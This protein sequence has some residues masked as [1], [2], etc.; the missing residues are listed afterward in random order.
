MFFVGGRACHVGDC[1]G[2]QQLAWPMGIVRLRMPSAAPSRSTLKLAEA[3][4]EFL[5]EKERERRLAP[6]T[7]AVDLGASPGGWTCQLVQRGM[8]VMAVDN[9]PIDANAC[10]IAAR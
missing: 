6:G 8:M 9:G 1:A 4:G 10:S 3:I 2:R 7:T 5:D